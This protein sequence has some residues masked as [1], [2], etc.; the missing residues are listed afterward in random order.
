M[1]GLCHWIYD[2]QSRHLIIGLVYK[3]SID[4]FN[5]GFEVIGW[6]VLQV[7][8]VRCPDAFGGSFYFGDDMFSMRHLLYYAL[9]SFSSALLLMLLFCI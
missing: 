2:V 7:V 9:H 8:Q 4:F 3:Y 6:V 1:L 5:I